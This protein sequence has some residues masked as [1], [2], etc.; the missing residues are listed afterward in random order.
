MATKA[1]SG[2]GIELMIGD[3]ATPEVFTKIAEITNNTRSK[4]VGEI[5]ATSYDS[6]A[7]EA[8]AG[9]VNN[10]TL[11]A[12]FNYVGSNAEQQKL[13]TDM[14]AGTT[15]NWRLRF[16]DHDVTKS[17]TDFAGFLTAFDI[18]NGGPNEKIA[19]S[20]SIRITGAVTRIYP[21]A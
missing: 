9:M 4:S 11:A 1:K 8:I 15:R 17:Q 7:E 3:G 12:G 16:M 10:G 19:G 20:F 6:V 2:K 5:D 18:S 13:E 14:D 21:P